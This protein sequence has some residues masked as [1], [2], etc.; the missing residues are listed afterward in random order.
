MTD[1]VLDNIPAGDDPRAQSH[2][3]ELCKENGHER[4]VALQLG[5]SSGLAT[6]V[7]TTDLI[8]CVPRTL[9]R[10][11]ATRQDVRAVELPF[12]IEPLEIAQFWHERYQRD[13]AHHWLRAMVYELF[14]DP[15][16][17]AARIDTARKRAAPARSVG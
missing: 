3:N 6:I 5:H 15:G 8:A 4:R 13:E 7:S 1:T 17:R 2:I 11:L 10:V 9:S 14:H 12:P 16:A